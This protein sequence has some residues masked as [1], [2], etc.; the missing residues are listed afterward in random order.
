MA[1]KG[2]A[3]GQTQWNARF[4]NGT[5][6]IGLGQ[7]IRCLFFIFAGCINSANESLI[8]MCLSGPP[9][10]VLNPERPS[11]SPPFLYHLSSAFPSYSGP[12]KLNA[13][14]NSYQKV[15]SILHY[16]K[17]Y[18]A[19]HIPIWITSNTSSVSN[20]LFQTLQ[21]PYLQS[22]LPVSVLVALVLKIFS[23][24]L[25]FFPLIP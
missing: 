4:S 22:G 2:W 12:R 1:L 25:L 14:I 18:K 23:H 11:F 10:L 20:P 16:L 17:L 7:R 21:N 3:E 15:T 6:A 13:G 24:V 8:D 5:R 19:S 9:S